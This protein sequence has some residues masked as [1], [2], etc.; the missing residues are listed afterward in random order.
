MKRTIFILLF[1]SL[2]VWSAEALFKRGV[3]LT[4][5]L[6]TSTA[7]QI[8]FTKFTK[9]DFINIKSLGCDVIR[10]PINLHFMTSGS[11][12]YTVAPLFLYFL[13]QIVDWAEELEIHLILDN[14][15]FDP[16]ADTDPNIGDILVPVWIQMAEHYKDRSTFLYYEVLNEPHGISDEIWN[17]IQQQVIDAIRTVDQKHTII[18][19]PAGWNSYHNLKNM[20]VYTD[21]NLIYTFHFYDPFLFTHQGASW[22]DPSL[23]PLSGVPFPYNAAG[24]P[25]CPLELLNTWVKSALD[26]YIN[27]GTVQHVKELIDIAADFKNNRN[28]PLFCGEFGVYIPN[29]NTE[30]RVY[31][32]EVVRHYLEEKDIAWTIW[33]YTGGFGLF[34]PGSNEMFDYDLNIPLIEALGFNV[35]PQKEFILTPDTTGFNLFQDFIGPQIIESSWVSNGIIDY[36]SETDPISDK[37]CIYWTEVDQYN[38]VGFKFLPIKD[39]SVLVEK[40]YAIDFW[41]RGDSPGSQFDIRFVDTKTDEPDDHPWRMRMT[42]DEKLATWNGKWNYLQIPLNDFTEQGSWDN[43]WF[44]PQGDF[45]WTAVD[46]FEIVS[47]HHDFKGIKFWLDNIRVIDPQAVSI[48]T[49][50]RIRAPRVFELYQNYPNPFNSSTIISY[51]IP[52]RTNVEL[53]IFNLLGQEIHTLLREKQ[54]GGDKSI[55]WEGKDNN[56]L[57]VSSGIYIYMLSTENSNLSRK[58]L[59]IR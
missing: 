41:I 44:D 33:D 49:E 30:D 8:Q 40:N 39:L 11:P 47:E 55:I 5:W 16:A 19:G 10:L 51:R 9:Q 1:I 2:K 52:E 22:T 27:E 13:D 20:P 37:Y 25:D 34:E 29:S 45:D 7:Q 6:Q 17:K 43:G 46:C 59:Y 26:N 12:D 38:K 56:G 18:I 54:D 15:T 28:V 3:N 58:M 23:I 21:N 48:E 35:P 4:N 36:Y 50:K 42:I 57:P 14:H 32:Y 31:W 53:K 24:M